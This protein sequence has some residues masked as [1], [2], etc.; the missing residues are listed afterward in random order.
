MSI[1]NSRRLYL[2]FFVS[3]FCSLVYQMIW[4]R[5]AFAFFGIITPVL[6][7]VLSVFMLG[8]AVGAWAGGRTIPW[9]VHKTGLS[10]I[11]FYG[12]AELI[13]GLGAF[14]TP[15]LFAVGQQCLLAAGQMDSFRYLLLS[16]LVL[17]VSI[18]PWCVCM[19]ATFPWMMAY[20]REEETHDVNS[21]SFL[22]YANVL[23]AMTG[24]IL[25]AFVFVETMGFRRTLTLAAAGNFAIA[26]VTAGMG[27]KARGKTRTRAPATLVPEVSPSGPTGGGRMRWILFTTGFSAMAMEVVWTRAFTPV[28]KTQVYSL[29]LIVFMYLGA[30]FLGSVL[31]RRHL[32]KDA[33]RPLGEL[34]ALLGL[35]AFLP[36]IAVDTWI[37]PAQWFLSNDTFLPD[38]RGVAFVLGSI[39]PMCGILG[40]LTPSLI[41]QYAAGHPAAAGKAYGINVIG[42][43]LGPLCASYF[44]LPHVSERYA[45]VILGLPL[46]S[47]AFLVRHGCRVAGQVCR[48]LRGGHGAHEVLCVILILR[49]TVGADERLQL[50]PQGRIVGREQLVNLATRVLVMQCLGDEINAVHDMVGQQVIQLTCLIGR[51]AQTFGQVG[52]EGGHAH[53][54]LVAQGFPGLRIGGDLVDGALAVGDGF[55]L[56]QSPH[57]TTQF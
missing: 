14:A 51:Q 38:S 28:L 8:L 13:I 11:F 56:A 53:F 44:L 52:V 6:S 1:S 46:L 39:C 4:T 25:T 19:G 49:Q 40:Y 23:G 35:T 57:F 10:A 33:R 27:W 47:L 54:L 24:T 12:G 26:A 30:T 3:G 34:V 32:R 20:V 7:V 43:I 36:I 50:V 17:A 5:L 9:L 37:L 45:L 42:C 48:E 21:F 15:G 31:Y 29:A 55:F 16:A 2:L 18:L 41:D 22:Y